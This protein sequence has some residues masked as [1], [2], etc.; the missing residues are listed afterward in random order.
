M[1]WEEGTRAD[2]PF[3]SRAVTAS[4]VPTSVFIL[5]LSR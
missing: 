2:E 1:T 3:V 5:V 4:S